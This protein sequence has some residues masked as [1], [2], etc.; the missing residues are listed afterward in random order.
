MQCFRAR[1]REKQQPKTQ[2]KSQK[3]ESHQ[4]EE[5]E[6]EWERNRDMPPK[7]RDKDALDGPKGQQRTDQIQA[8]H[9]LFLQAFESEFRGLHLHKL[10]SNYL[11]LSCANSV[12]Q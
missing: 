4:E 12:I 10:L 1:A 6:E 3:Q 9:E 5:E 8:D 11:L 2:A 7:K